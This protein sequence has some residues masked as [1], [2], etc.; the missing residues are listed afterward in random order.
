MYLCV[1]KGGASY[2]AQSVKDL[3]AM[4]EF[5]SWVGKIPWRR[6]WQPNDVDCGVVM[7]TMQGKLASSQFDF[8]YTEEF[9]ITDVTPG[10][11][12][13]SVYPKSN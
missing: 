6:K 2:V 7:E 11:Q 12:N 13:C 10:M 1:S 8:G 5:D 4:L 9:C 3:P